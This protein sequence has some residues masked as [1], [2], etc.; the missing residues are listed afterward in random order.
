MTIAINNSINSSYIKK[1]SLEKCIK[2]D[3]KIILY[4]SPKDYSSLTS[5]I[6]ILKNIKNRDEF[7]CPFS[8]DFPNTL[9]LDLSTLHSYFTDYEG[10]ISIKI[11]ENTIETILTPILFQKNIVNF[12]DTTNNSSFKWFI[13]VLD[14]GELR[15]SSIVNN[16]ALG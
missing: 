10:S 7:I 11:Q 1:I 6:I 16:K 8:K 5:S 9:T 2:N 4:F 15:L 3:N 13:R 14:N 12:E